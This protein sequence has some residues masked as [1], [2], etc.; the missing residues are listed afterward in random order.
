MRVNG[1]WDLGNKMEYFNESR[2]KRIIQNPK[3]SNENYKEAMFRLHKTHQGPSKAVRY[4]YR[5]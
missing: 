3:T 4:R 2:L 1:N 5:N